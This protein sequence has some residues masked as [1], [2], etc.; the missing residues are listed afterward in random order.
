MVKSKKIKWTFVN[1]KKESL[2]YKTRSTF[3]KKSNGAYNSARKNGW[4]DEICNH[5]KKNN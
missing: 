2:I 5:M 3:C 1:C 4:L